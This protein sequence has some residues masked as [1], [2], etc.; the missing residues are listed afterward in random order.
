MD[1]LL[2]KEYLKGTKQHTG[3]KLVQGAVARKAYWQV[4]PQPPAPDQTTMF[5]N[6]FVRKSRE[7]YLIS[8]QTS[9]APPPPSF[10]G[11]SLWL[12]PPT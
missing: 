1:T 10:A 11:I 8:P 3:N 2:W 4:V 12:S 5:V 6:V 9:L 7:N